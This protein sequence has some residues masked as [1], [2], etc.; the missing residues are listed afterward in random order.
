M[1]EL[2]PGQ[3]IRDVWAGNLQ[4]EMLK[5]RDIAEQYPYVSMDTE[6]PGVVAKAVGP[7]RTPKEYN[8]QT[9]KC[10]V[11][12]LKVI[13]IGLTFA[14]DTGKRPE[15]I[16]TWQFN[17]SFDLVQDLYAQESVDFL[18][19]C[20]LDFERHTAEGIDVQ[21]FAEL[22]MSSG[23]VLDPEVHW[24]SFHGSYDFGYLLKILT[25]QPLPDEEADFFDLLRA[26]FPSLYDI[27]FMLRSVE[28]LRPTWT[29]SLNM[30]CSYLDVHR[31]G[32]EHQAGSDSLVTSHC[33]FCLVEKYL[34]N[35]I[36]DSKY[37]GVIYGLG[38]GASAENQ[39][40]S[41]R[42]PSPTSNG[43][44]S[45]PTAVM[46]DP[47]MG[48]PKAMGLVDASGQPFFLQNGMMS[49]MHGMGRPMPQ[50]A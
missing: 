1:A 18:R 37:A 24:I 36:D 50:Y 25:C 19:Q 17:F 32:Q 41:F 3:L 8:Y 15:G 42:S 20:G 47:M 28:K 9:V 14:D 22:L 31:V 30:L 45:P 10:N 49:G 27:K 44:E 16:C 43:R 26:Y 29:S 12:L 33:F 5:M 11:D 38:E 23:I 4:E 21:D 7:F 48:T 39:V 40:D 46:R 35:Q 2:D 13:Q 6:F 34:E